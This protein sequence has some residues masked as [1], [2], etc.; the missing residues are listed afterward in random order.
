MVRTSAFHIVYSNNNISY[1]KAPIWVYE[2][3]EEDLF[4][5]KFEY[6]EKGYKGMRFS[7]RKSRI[8]Y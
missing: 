3:K 1:H 6:K 4:P 5:V 8:E 2:V 7:D